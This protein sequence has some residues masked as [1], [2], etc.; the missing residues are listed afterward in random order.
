MAMRCS[1]AVVG[2][3]EKRPNIKGFLKSYRQRREKKKITRETGG[4]GPGGV[5]TTRGPTSAREEFERGGV[6]VRV[7]ESV[8]E[9]HCMKR[10]RKGMTG[11]EHNKILPT[12]CINGP[13][14]QKFPSHF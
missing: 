12:M 10:H 9:I 8:T 14:H 2:W 6:C 1:V 7:F 3:R 5:D 13:H 11:C 4:G